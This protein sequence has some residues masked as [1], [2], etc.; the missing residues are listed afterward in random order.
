MV[1]VVNSLD[2]CA[3]WRVNS[4]GSVAALLCTLY[5]GAIIMNREECK[6]TFVLSQPLYL[7]EM[8][9]D[10][11]EFLSFTDFLE[12]FA[13]SIR[14]TRLPPSWLPPEEDERPFAVKL[15][16]GLHMLTTGIHAGHDSILKRNVTAKGLDRLA[17]QGFLPD[18]D[19]GLGGG[20]PDTDAAPPKED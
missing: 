16:F 7:D 1:P 18:M 2:P 15:A 9:T 11:Y 5:C 17:A 13:R 10:S 6:L 19:A 12:A 8:V 14:E 3:A 20:L 4:W